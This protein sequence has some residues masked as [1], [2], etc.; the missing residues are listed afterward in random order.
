[1]LIM[2]VEANRFG[3]HKTTYNL[4][5]L[6]LATGTIKWLITDKPFKLCSAFFWEI[7]YFVCL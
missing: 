3:L 5:N 4:R 1:M 2:L 7:M 6:Y